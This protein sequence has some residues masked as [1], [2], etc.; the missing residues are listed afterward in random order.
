MTAYRDGVRGERQRWREEVI[1]NGRVVTIKFEES[2]IGGYRL[3]KP[4]TINGRTISDF[5]Y[6]EPD[7]DGPP[8]PYAFADALMKEFG[9]I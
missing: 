3:R 6:D 8:N 1:V 2:F 5:H 9:Y 4:V 7:G